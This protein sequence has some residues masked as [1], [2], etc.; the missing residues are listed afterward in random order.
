MKVIMETID[1]SL[2]IHMF[3]ELDHHYSEEIRDKID[4]KICATDVSTLI[5]E[6]SNV[7][8]MDSS[9]IG[10]LMGRYRLMQAQG[11]RVVIAG[12]SKSIEKIWDVS[13]LGKIIPR[14]SDIAQALGGMEVL[15]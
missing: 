5:L 15:R 11:G 4:A 9:G 14:Y 10:V 7:A 12:I 2:I 13:G 3:G 8:F 1:K 6:L